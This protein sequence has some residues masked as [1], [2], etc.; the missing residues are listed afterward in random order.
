MGTF[1]PFSLVLLACSTSTPGG[2]YENVTAMSFLGDLIQ[3]KP[4]PKS[5]LLMLR[6]T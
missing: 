2:E 5:L 4:L 3:A 6:P 1:E